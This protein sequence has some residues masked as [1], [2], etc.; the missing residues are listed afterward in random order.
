MFKIEDT[1]I[2]QRFNDGKFLKKD[3]RKVFK[4]S[5]NHFGLNTRGYHEIDLLA[6][7]VD[8]GVVFCH[9]GQWAEEK[10]K[11]TF[12]FDLMCFNSNGELTYDGSNGELPK[13]ECYKVFDDCNE[14]KHYQ[15]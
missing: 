6:K 2:V 12:D 10:A 8:G 7:K 11:N 1:E 4:D 9:I 13:Y 14:V 15:Y 5:N 3:L